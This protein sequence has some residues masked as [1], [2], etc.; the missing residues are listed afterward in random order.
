MPGDAPAGVRGRV[1]EGEAAEVTEGP[2]KG[3]RGPWSPK[4]IPA[5]PGAGRELSCRYVTWRQPRRSRIQLASRGRYRHS[6]SAAR[7]AGAPGAVATVIDSQSV[8]AADTVGKDSRSY[9]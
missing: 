2:F 9:D 7:W 4:E 6:A 1:D 3:R 8:K 5:G